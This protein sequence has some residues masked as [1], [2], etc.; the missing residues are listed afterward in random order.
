MQA[1]S[2]QH[3]RFLVYCYDLLGP[4]IALS[5]KERYEGFTQVARTT[6]LLA[7]WKT[8]SAARDAIVMKLATATH[9]SKRAARKELRIL[10]PALLASEFL[11]SE[12]REW[13]SQKTR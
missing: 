2:R 8:K 4:G 6:R 10:K 7:A 3:W 5:K 13:L 11:D 9:M 1:R 12:E